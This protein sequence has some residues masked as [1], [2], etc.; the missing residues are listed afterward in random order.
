MENQLEQ[1]KS[2]RL[3]AISQGSGRKVLAIR[4]SVKHSREIQ[5]G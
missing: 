1:Q 4:E 5:S 3:Y 2:I